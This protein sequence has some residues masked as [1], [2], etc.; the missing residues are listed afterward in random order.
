MKI[1]QPQKKKKKKQ[2]I[3]WK[4]KTPILFNAPPKTPKKY[5][6]PKN[7]TLFKITKSKSKTFQI[8]QQ[9]SNLEAPIEEPNKFTPLSTP[10]KPKLSKKH[11]DGISTKSTKNKDF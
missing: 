4:V 11:P 1:L 3:A 8:L 9:M 5:K 10:R 7:H 6:P 2:E